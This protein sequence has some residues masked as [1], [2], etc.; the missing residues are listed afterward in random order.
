ML[1]TLQCPFMWEKQ[2]KTD[3]SNAIYQFQSSQQPRFSVNTHTRGNL[4]RNAGACRCK[5]AMLHRFQQFGAGQ[6]LA[7]AG[8]GQK[9]PMKGCV[10]LDLLV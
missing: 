5:L 2:R 10:Y 8:P 4:I 7:D 6:A 9:D 3:S 1:R